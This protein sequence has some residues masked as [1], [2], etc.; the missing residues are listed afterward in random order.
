M[1]RRKKRLDHGVK[2]SRL[3]EGKLQGFHEHYHEYRPP[4][5]EGGAQ[6]ASSQIDDKRFRNHSYDDRN[7]FLNTSCDV[8][9]DVVEGNPTY[10]DAIPLLP[11]H[12]EDTPEGLAR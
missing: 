5:P 12:N 11:T 2:L 8:M 10:M 6:A 7:S 3:S 1:A 9:A 4:E